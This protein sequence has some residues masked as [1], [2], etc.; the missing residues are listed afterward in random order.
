MSRFWLTWMGTL[1]AASVMPPDHPA[2]FSAVPRQ[3]V[4][5][6]QAQTRRRQSTPNPIPPRRPLYFRPIFWLVLVLGAGLAGGV[7]RG[8]R[9]WQT[10]HAN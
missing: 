2:F 10:T 7:T 8:Y 9:I 4:Y 3:R 6:P 5:K 1:P